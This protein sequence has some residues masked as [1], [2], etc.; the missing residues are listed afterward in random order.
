MHVLVDEA[1]LPRARRPDERDRRTA[2]DRQVEVVEDG[3]RR[4]AEGHVFER[5]LPA[6][7]RQ[8]SGVGSPRF[9]GRRRG[10]DFPRR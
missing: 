8:R 6:N 3:R 4:V 2:R 9:P 5:D 1:R 7:R 10:A